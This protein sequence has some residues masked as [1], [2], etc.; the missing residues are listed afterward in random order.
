M[1]KEIY[2]SVLFV[3]E[4]QTVS[5]A[6]VF[7]AFFYLL[8]KAGESAGYMS[9]PEVKIYYNKKFNPNEKFRDLLNKLNKDFDSIKINKRKRSFKRVDIAFAPKNTD[10]LKFV[11]FGE[12]YTIDGAFQCLK[13]CEVWKALIEYYKKKNKTMIFG[14]QP[15]ICYFI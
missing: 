12:I 4:A 2:F 14:F 3:L 8:I 10:K 6:K 5:V 7:T 1:K 9:I 13:T 15:M 11:G